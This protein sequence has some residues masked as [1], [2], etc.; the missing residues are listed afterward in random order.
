MNLLQKSLGL[1]ILT[2]ASFGYL[3]PASAQ[4]HHDHGHYD[5]S[6]GD[7]HGHGHV[8][9]HHQHGHGHY[10]G[11]QYVYPRPSGS[12]YQPL[13]PNSLPTPPVAFSDPVVIVNPSDSGGNVNYEIGSWRFTIQPGQRQNLPGDRAWVIRFHRGEGFGEAKYR[14][15]AGTY[16]FAPSSAGWALVRDRA[17]GPDALQAPPEIRTGA[18]DPK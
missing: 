1:S 14:L 6:H 12:Y 2:L 17:H 9:D 10:D 3:Q 18:A 15:D 8:Y 5:D 4:H 13:S 16:R 11:Y 7:F